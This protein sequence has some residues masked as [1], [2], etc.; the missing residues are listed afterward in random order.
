VTY[1]VRTV[2][3]DKTVEFTTPDNAYL[4]ARRH[5]NLTTLVVRRD[6]TTQCFARD[7]QLL[8]AVP[9]DG[10]AGM[11]KGTFGHCFNCLGEGAIPGRE[12]P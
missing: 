3:S 8:T 12:T 11:G 4:H 5:S 10:C 9:C 2:G 1:R 6:N 7:G